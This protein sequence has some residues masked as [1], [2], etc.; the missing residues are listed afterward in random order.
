MVASLDPKHTPNPNNFS[1]IK[2]LTPPNYVRQFD[3]L[4]DDEIACLTYRMADYILHGHLFPD[5]EGFVG[6][7]D[8]WDFYM[9]K[10]IGQ[11]K[12]PSEEPAKA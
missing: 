9:G 1:T 7:W 6:G 12:F 5:P 11:I 4:N 8:H 3:S 10:A 2:I